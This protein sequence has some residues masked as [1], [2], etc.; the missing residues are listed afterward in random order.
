LADITFNYLVAS[1]GADEQTF[2]R[3]CL[4]PEL[5]VSAEVSFIFGFTDA[6]KTDDLLCAAA[7]A[8]ADIVLLVAAGVAI[9]CGKYA[10]VALTS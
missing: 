9:G 1:N 2:T 5:G 6:P 8:D 10:D 7:F 3:I 4:G